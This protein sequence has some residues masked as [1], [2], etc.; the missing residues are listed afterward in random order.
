MEKG[1]GHG[2]WTWEGGEGTFELSGMSVVTVHNQMSRCPKL[3]FQP[4][5]DENEM[6]GIHDLAR[7]SVLDCDA[8]LRK[9][10]Y[11]NILLIG[12]STM[13]R[14]FREC[15]E[16][17]LNGHPLCRMQHFGMTVH[18]RLGSA[19]PA[20]TL[21]TRM[22]QMIATRVGTCHGACKRQAWDFNDP[23]AKVIAPPE[24]RISAWNGGSILASLSDFLQMTISS[25]SHPQCNPAIVGYEEV[26]PRIVNMMCG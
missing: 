7:K 21:D 2:R 6:L 14:N 11:Q 12:G 19:S 15:M 1:D 22:M 8:D 5:L 13:F 9:G 17:E 18:P 4:G 16:L 25:I 20:R 10:L 23:L 24:R 3:L 26:G